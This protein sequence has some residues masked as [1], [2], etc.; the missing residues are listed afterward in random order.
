MKVF[1]AER[2]LIL[3]EHRFSRGETMLEFERDDRDGG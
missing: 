1:T 3:T 2:K